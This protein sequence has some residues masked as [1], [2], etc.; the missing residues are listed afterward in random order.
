MLKTKFTLLI[1]VVWIIMFCF[2]NDSEAATEKLS[3]ADRYATSAIIAENGWKQSDYAILAYGKSF[4]DA[5]IAAP[6]AKKYNAPILL[7]ESN[8]VPKDTLN[9]I[10]Q[11]KITHIII[12]GGTGIISSSVENHLTSLGINTTRLYGQDKYETS[13]I[14]AN[15]LD[16]VNQIAIVTD[17]DF[18]DAL[19]ISPIAAKM[20]MPIILIPH[21]V[22][23]DVV[24]GYVKTHGISKTY[25]IGV[26]SSLDKSLVNE[27]PNVEQINGQD[28]YQ[29]NLA[30]LDKFKSEMDLDTIYLTSGEYFDDGLSGCALASANCNP[31]LLVSENSV[32]QKNYLD[33]HEITK[34]NVVVLGGLVKE[35][36]T[37][38][39]S[40]TTN[41][42]EKTIRDV[43]NVAPQDITKIVF[44]D[45]RGGLN[46]PLT[47]EDKQDISKFMDYLDG[48]VLEKAKNP[49]PSTGWIHEAA[50]YMNDKEVMDITFVDPIIINK[51]YYTILKS[52]LDNKK[53]DTFLKSIDPTY[54]I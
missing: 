27:L 9:M 39:S 16:N 8:F 41:Y 42:K 32:L 45:G 53:I 13:I 22:L 12:I 1:I 14:V 50:F 18:A 2:P 10:Q 21:N 17:E 19:S 52:T 6:L 46:K 34:Y 3:G 38:A 30:V 36:A 48:Y 15:H 31:L 43:T 35:E 28:K 7:T 49:E 40:S 5:L 26:G 47:I 23:P 25:I 20:N 54:V 37:L 51:N 4:P 24:R 33:E 44:Y 11:L 29:R